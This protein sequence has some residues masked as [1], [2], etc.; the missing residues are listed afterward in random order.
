MFYEIARDN[1][2]YIIHVG[3]HW[4]SGRISSASLHKGTLKVHHVCNQKYRYAARSR[5]YEHN[6]IKQF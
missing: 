1:I 6:N 3:M 5:T 4:I 2:Q